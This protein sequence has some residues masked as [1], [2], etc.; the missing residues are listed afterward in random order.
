MPI[1]IP[2][3][4]N[5]RFQYLVDAATRALPPQLVPAWTD[6]NV[7]DPGITLLEA[8]AERLDALSYRF[9]T[10]SPSAREALVNQMSTAPE[11]SKIE[12]ASPLAKEVLTKLL[13]QK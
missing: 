9:G 1:P 11:G 12:N 2:D 5:L 7:S 13:L 4:D 3:L 10:L 8:C 6:H